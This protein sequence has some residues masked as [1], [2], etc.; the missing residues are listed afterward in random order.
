[1]SDHKARFLSAADLLP[2]A[3]RF[4][5]AELRGDSFRPP[6]RLP[7]QARGVLR[8]TDRGQMTG[9]VDELTPAEILPLTGDLQ[10]HLSLL[11][12]DPG[13]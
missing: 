5:R 1:M 9:M 3:R 13:R 8:D 6:R 10:P 7:G 4:L 2:T 12:D 11:P